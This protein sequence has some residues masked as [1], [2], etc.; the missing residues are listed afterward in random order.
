MG[1]NDIWTFKYEP[2]K[3]DDIILNKDIR[4]KL[5]KAMKEVPN[6]LLYG[7]PGVGKGTFT[8]IFL[9]ETGLDYLWVNASDERGIDVMRDKIKSFAT[10]LGISGMKVVVL[11][12]G[13][14]LTTEAQRMLRQ[15][16]E[17]VHKVTRFIFLANYEHLFIPEIKS[18]C[19]VIEM[20]N[21]P[22]ADILKFCEHI[23]K[24]EG[25][26]YDRKVVASVIKKCYPDIRNTIWRLQ[27][28]TI[29]NVLKG[30]KVSNSEDL[31]QSILHLMKSSDL[32][33]IRKSLKSNSVD[34]IGLYEYLFENVGDFKSPGDAIIEIGEHLYRNDNAAIKEINFIHMFVKMMKGGMI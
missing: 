24:S 27:E 26:K 14:A 5:Y 30:D 2:K 19:Q 17:D 1:K 23:L 21:P 6:M 31:F 33:G 8:H 7:K 10:A 11:N 22:G 3:F 25:V 12:E 29:D 32:E 9:N 13:D 28:N 4:P 16:I 20:S 34:Y 15:L 18:R